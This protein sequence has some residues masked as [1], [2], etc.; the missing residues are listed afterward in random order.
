MA[1][2]NLEFGIADFNNKTPRTNGS[3]AKHRKGSFLKFR[4]RDRNRSQC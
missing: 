3:N 2:N 1:N 4:I